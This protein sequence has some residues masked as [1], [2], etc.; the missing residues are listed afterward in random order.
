[1]SNTINI[2]KNMIWVKCL[3]CNGICRVGEDVCGNCLE[4]AL[5]EDYDDYDNS[6]EDAVIEMNLNDPLPDDDEIEFLEDWMFDEDDD[7]FICVECGSKDAKPE[8]ML[9]GCCVENNNKEKKFKKENKNVD[10]LKMNED[11]MKNF[12][13][14]RRPMDFKVGSDDYKEYQRLK[15]QISRYRS[16]VSLNEVNV[17]DKVEEKEVKKKEKPLKRKELD[18]EKLN[19]IIPSDKLPSSSSLRDYWL[20]IDNIYRSYFRV[21]L[22]NQNIDLLE[23]ANGVL[24]FLKEKYDKNE[25]SLRSNVS[26]I[27]TILKKTGNDGIAKLYQSEFDRLSRKMDEKSKENKMSDKEKE[28]WISW[29]EIEKLVRGHYKDLTNTEKLVVN[30]YMKLVCPRRIKDFYKMKVIRLNNVGNTITNA[31]W[32][33]VENEKDYNW[34]LIGKSGKIVAMV[35]NDYK[36]KEIYG[37]VVMIGK[38]VKIT[39]VRREDDWFDLGEM[40]QKEM[41]PLVSMR[42]DGDFLLGGGLDEPAMSRLVSQTFQR[43]TG[44]D[45]GCS[46]LRKIFITDRIANNPKLSLKDRERCG[47]G[48]GHSRE[49]Q[50]RYMRLKEE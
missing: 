38:G 10:K 27:Y 43:A 2:K 11:T 26:V 16:K 23:D 42:E 21:Y 22:T 18:I 49:T 36:T 48:M 8:N 24:N 3:T 1:M 33:K 31:V 28:R 47:K 37:S 20:K 34:V 30:L 35:F 15:R 39:G 6:M 7:E 25:S 40:F 44:K 4:D 5:E 17:N 9:C 14:G 46:M 50:A 32:K 29:N 45:L 13:N 41:I 19:E 12:L